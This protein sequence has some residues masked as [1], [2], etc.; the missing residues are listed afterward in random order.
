MALTFPTFGF[1]H[2]LNNFRWLIPKGPD[3]CFC[4]LDYVSFT[5]VVTLCTGGGRGRGWS[6][7]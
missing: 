1:F 5:D 7:I 3:L 6:S 2:G 4:S